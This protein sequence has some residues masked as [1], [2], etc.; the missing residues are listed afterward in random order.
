MMRPTAKSASAH[1]RVCRDVQRAES[2]RRQA[3][4]RPGKAR[5]LRQTHLTLLGKAPARRQLARA[6]H[7]GGSG[8]RG[9][10]S[11]R[12]LAP[13]RHRG[14]TQRATPR[15]PRRAAAGAWSRACC[16]HARPDPAAREPPRAF[17]G[18]HPLAAARPLWRNDTAVSCA[19]LSLLRAGVWL[20]CRRVPNAARLRGKRRAPASPASSVGGGGA[21][22]S[23]HHTRSRL[24]IP[25]NS[26]RSV[27]NGGC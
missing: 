17:E 6:V 15:R 3:R 24:P 20:H 5:C 11:G 7:H 19:A 14:G 22:C 2:A 25:F 12:S 16:H 1:V 13:L 18:L 21:C 10:P 23:G 4:R 26:V 27:A 9:V 8:P